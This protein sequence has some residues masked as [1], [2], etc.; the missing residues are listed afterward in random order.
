M[1]RLLVAVGVTAAAV[2]VPAGVAGADPAGPSDYA[3]V[4]VG[5][6]PATSTIQVDVIGG[7]SFIQLTAEAGT[8][9]VVLGYWGEPYLRFGVDGRVEEN[10][11]S[12]TVAENEDR[13]G[14]SSGD[15]ATADAQAQWVEVATDGSYAWHDH[16][17]HWMS[18]EP[19]AG[20][21][22]DQVLTGTIPLQVDGRTVSVDVAVWWEPSPSR[23]PLVAGAL[24]GGFA[25]MIVL[26]VRHRVAWALAAAAAAAAGIG[27][28]QVVS[29]PPET[30]PSS[31]SWLLPA[32]AGAAAVVALTLGRSL[33]SY[34]LVALAGV[35]LG[36]WAFVRRDGL[37][38][39]LLPT[40]APFWLDRGVTA[41][42]AVVAL[43]G[44]VAGGIG[45]LRLPAAS[46]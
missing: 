37:V 27:W 1:K 32:V 45:M 33:I 38:R 46:G 22:G 39:A 28:W 35:Q 16:R 42:A 34:G 23:L 8:E 15:G 40:E 21:P 44:I 18:T 5:I 26:S 4:V 43:V 31:I 9:V 29:V 13:Y 36:L 10:R 2:A 6:E 7:D 12:P 14:R 19:P 41:A 24:L 17:A 11:R 20:E 30:G 3:T 25:V